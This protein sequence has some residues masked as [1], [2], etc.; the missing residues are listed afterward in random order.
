M[1]NL[2]PGRKIYQINAH[3]IRVVCPSDGP[4][5]ERVVPVL[6]NHNRGSADSAIATATV[7]A[8]TNFAVFKRR[9]TSEFKEGASNSQATPVIA[10]A[11]GTIVAKKGVG[12]KKDVEKAKKIKDV[13]DADM[14]EL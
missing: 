14:M 2:E 1:K 12:R 13:V 11:G 4:P 5:I 8:F 10:V 3:S 7:A 9:K 6:P